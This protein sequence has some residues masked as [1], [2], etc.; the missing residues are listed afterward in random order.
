MQASRAPR[1]GAGWAV[2]AATMLLLVGT[3]NITCGITPLADDQRFVADELFFGDLSFKG[4][5]LLIIGGLLL[6]AGRMILSGSAI[7]VML[8]ILLA[9]FNAIAQVLAIG[10][11]PFWSVIVLV[12]DGMIIYELSASGEALS[13]D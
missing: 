10:A 6:V 7:G 1:G 2:F 8:G 3:I 9:G 5:V 12:I 4:V 11:Y 13:A